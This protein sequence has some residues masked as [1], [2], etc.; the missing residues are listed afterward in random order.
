MHAAYLACK[1]YKI[2]FCT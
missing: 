2:G 1:I